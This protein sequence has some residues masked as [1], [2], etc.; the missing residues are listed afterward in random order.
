MYL[1]KS[2]L[3]FRLYIILLYFKQFYIEFPLVSCFL[4]NTFSVIF[5]CIECFL[6]RKRKKNLDVTLIINIDIMLSVFPLCLTKYQPCLSC[7]METHPCYPHPVES[8]ILC[9]CFAIIIDDV[10]AVIKWPGVDV[11]YTSRLSP[12]GLFW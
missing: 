4:V 11:D 3:T 10:V 8:W 7:S 5:G 2:W 12:L 9:I 1:T 6:K